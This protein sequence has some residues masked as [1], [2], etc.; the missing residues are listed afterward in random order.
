E[1][2]VWKSMPSS[3]PFEFREKDTTPLVE[4]LQ[5]DNFSM[6]SLLLQHGA[7]PNFSCEEGSPLVVAAENEDIDSLTMLLSH[8][9]N[10]ELYFDSSQ[11]I[12]AKILDDQYIGEEVKRVVTQ[13]SS[14]KSRDSAP[15]LATFSSPG[16]FFSKL[17]IANEN[18]IDK[19]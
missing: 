1:D 2:W 13:Q 12:K 14:K 4:A 3:S 7:D 5:K 9:A 11:T 8:G 18:Q 6:V 15:T 19:E 10:L 16:N 17:T